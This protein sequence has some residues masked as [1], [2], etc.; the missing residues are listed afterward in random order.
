MAASEP[1]DRGL[2]SPIATARRDRW[3][4]RPLPGGPSGCT[5]DR[6]PSTGAG[7]A[8]AWP[9][10]GS[11]GV[12]PGSQYRSEI[13]T[14]SP[15]QRIVAWATIHDIDASGHW[16][17]KTVTRVSESSQLWPDP[18]EIQNYLGRFP[19]GCK[20]PFAAPS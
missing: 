16:P 12:L 17:G 2:G 11:R 10:S 14:T 5:P 8:T 13:F 18:P 9:D 1:R 15:D 19:D 7:E 6:W 3:T 20:P 4:R